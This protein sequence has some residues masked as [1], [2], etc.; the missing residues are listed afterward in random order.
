MAAFT[1]PSPTHVCAIDSDGYSFTIS[2][3]TGQYPAIPTGW[4]TVS[5]TPTGTAAASDVT[6]SSLKVTK[7]T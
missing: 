2:E 6:N 3:T 5:G 1:A 4:A 7:P